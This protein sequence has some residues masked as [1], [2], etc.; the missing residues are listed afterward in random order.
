MSGISKKENSD[1][2]SR[3]GIIEETV[4]VVRKRKEVV[5][6]DGKGEGE[7]SSLQ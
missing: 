7:S 1:V 4:E 3:W 2:G 6:G 5:V